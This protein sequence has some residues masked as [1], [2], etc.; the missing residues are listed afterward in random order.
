MKI[1]SAIRVLLIGCLSIPGC[2]TGSR[3]AGAPVEADLSL[4]DVD[5][6]KQIEDLVGAASRHPGDARRRAELGMAYEVSGLMEAALASYE[7]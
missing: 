7:Q 2:A 4:T 6:A 1:T 5:S 3:E